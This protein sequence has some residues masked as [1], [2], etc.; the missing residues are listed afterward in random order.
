MRQSLPHCTGREAALNGLHTKWPAPAQQPQQLQG[1]VAQVASN[2]Q[3][4]R[5]RSVQS[6]KWVANQGPRPC[7]GPEL[8]PCKQLS[9]LWFVKPY[10]KEPPTDAGESNFC[11]GQTQGTGG[12]LE[13]LE[14]ASAVGGSIVSTAT[15]SAAPALLAASSCLDAATA[16]TK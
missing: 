15:A 9:I 10:A 16:S 13:N 2:H 8:G 1:T 5:G 3:L 14:S 12:R 7:G 6:A 4:S 11:V